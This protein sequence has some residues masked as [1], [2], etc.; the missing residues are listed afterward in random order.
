MV[1][2]D[3]LDLHQQV[4]AYLADHHVMTLATTGE[5]GVWAAAVF[6]ASAG[7]DFIFLSAAHTRHAQNL[8]LN[9]QV[10][11]TVQE[12]YRDWAEIK[13]I[14]GAGVVSLLS[15]IERVTA[16]SLY[17]QKFPFLQHAPPPVRTALDKINWYR[18][19]PQR[20]YFIDNSKGFGHRDEVLL[21]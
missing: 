8:T 14:Q 5:A 4:L 7:F 3:S 17:L 15:G 18:L 13:G 12:D 1:D 9:G 6:Y 10:A 2:N 16:V 20:L 19:R 11:V 21:P